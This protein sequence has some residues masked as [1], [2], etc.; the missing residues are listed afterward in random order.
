VTGQLLGAFGHLVACV[1]E[2]ASL[3]FTLNR[4]Y[5][6]W[7]SR[8]CPSW[9]AD[10]CTE[11]DTTLLRKIS[12]LDQCQI[13]SIECHIPNIG[14]G[15]SLLGLGRRNTEQITQFSW[16]VHGCCGCLVFDVAECFPTDRSDRIWLCEQSRRVGLTQRR[17][18]GCGGWACTD[19]RGTLRCLN[20]R[21]GMQ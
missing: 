14:D 2:E 18:C 4:L 8:Y 7:Y 6:A 12:S 13:S 9:S 15:V 19:L 11:T 17:F 1:E 5:S 16:L 10:V 3:G 20:N 21:S